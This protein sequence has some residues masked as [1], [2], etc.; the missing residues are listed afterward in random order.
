MP[1]T[2]RPH[3]SPPVFQ[4]R[5][6]QKPP[7][8]KTRN[9]WQDKGHLENAPLVARQ[10]AP[11]VKGGGARA[12]NTKT[13]QIQ[14]TKSGRA[15]LIHSTIH[16]EPRVHAGLKRIA[17]EQGLSFSEV[18]NAAGRFYIAATIEQQHAESLRD[19][20]RQIMREELAAFGHRIVYFLLRIAFAAE[21]GKT[22][23][24]IGSFTPVR[25]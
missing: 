6:K 3:L 12:L 24:A 19:I 17:D 13:A 18:G 10:P 20:V 16:F 2:I 7:A 9:V 15:K 5:Q 1:N 23:S 25:N 22:N 11:F 8:R 21:Q 14:K 4:N